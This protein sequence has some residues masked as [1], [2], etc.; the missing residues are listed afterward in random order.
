MRESTYVTL[1]GSAVCHRGSGPDGL[2]RSE[3]VQVIAEHSTT[4]GLDTALRYW[5]LKRLRRPL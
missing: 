4:Y 5:L 3:D 2:D 1:G